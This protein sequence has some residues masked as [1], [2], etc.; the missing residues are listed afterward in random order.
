MTVQD[1]SKAHQ[2]SATAV[3]D[4]AYSV[5]RTVPEPR[6]RRTGS[7]RAQNMNVFFSSRCAKRS[8]C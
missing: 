7:T 5:F 4:P 2:L 6:L 8:F 1:L 3:I